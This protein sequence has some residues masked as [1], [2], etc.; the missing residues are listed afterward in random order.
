MEV[1]LLLPEKPMNTDNFVWKYREWGMHVLRSVVMLP[2]FRDKAHYA[3]SFSCTAQANQCWSG[4]VAASV[5]EVGMSQA[6]SCCNC[7]KSGAGLTWRVKQVTMIWNSNVNFKIELFL[8]AWRLWAA[9]WSWERVSASWD[10]DR[11]CKAVNTKD[12]PIT[13]SP[14]IHVKKGTTQGH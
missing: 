10:M 6:Q 8:K 11:Q 2:L 9:C 5:A 3:F 13:N 7:P 12:F 4:G 1:R 14:C